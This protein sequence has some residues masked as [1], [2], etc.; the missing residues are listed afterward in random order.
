LKC[1]VSIKLDRSVRLGKKEIYCLT[2]VVLVS[3]FLML[4]KITS[5][6]NYWI[7]VEFFNYPRMPYFREISPFGLGLHRCITGNLKLMHFVCNWKPLHLD[8]LSDFFF[9]CGNFKSCGNCSLD[10]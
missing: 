7:S 4:S 2:D 1:S 8:F 9:L 10:N 6:S 5:L 3:L